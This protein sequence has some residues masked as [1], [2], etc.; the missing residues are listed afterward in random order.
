LS[1]LIRQ[2][3][4][5][6]WLYFPLALVLG[7]LH[8]LEPGHSK[9]M[10]AAFIIAVRGTVGQA[11]LLGL[12]AALSHSL[13]IWVLAF[14][15]FHF[16]QNWS[17]EN[18]E[19][20]LQLASGLI[21]IAM[22]IWMMWRTHRDGHHHHDHDHDHGH[23]HDHDHPHDHDHDHGKDD[24]LA[25][26]ET[27]G[28]SEAFKG[29]HLDAHARAHAREIQE[30]FSGRQATTGQIVLFGLTGG[31]LPCPGALTVLLL[32]LQLK[33]AALGFWL[34]ACFSVGLAVTL[35]LAGVVAAWGAAHAAK[36][37]SKLGGLSRWA[38]RAPYVSGAVMVVLGV[39]LAWTGWL[40]LPR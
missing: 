10:M 22:A 39:V 27:A 8:G 26:L 1:E 12:L 6:P 32:C 34:V 40:H 36:K 2:G 7:A 29:E 14:G 33:K 5:H 35:V 15:A 18:S 9:T 31:L 23:S 3:A 21:V 20:W 4:G 25:P 16:G 19:P 17:A 30:K 11:A 13:L 38:D 37:L 28:L 24:P